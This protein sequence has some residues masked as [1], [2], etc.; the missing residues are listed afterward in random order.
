MDAGIE[1]VQPQMP[2]PPL[3]TSDMG[4]WQAW[5]LCE[6]GTRDLALASWCLLEKGLSIS[7]YSN[8]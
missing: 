4:M 7:R 2:E 8:F 5:A 1:K 6:R 3:P